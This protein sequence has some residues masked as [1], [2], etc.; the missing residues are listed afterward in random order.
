MTPTTPPLYPL[1]FIP[2]YQQKIWGG[3]EICKYKSLPISLREIGETWEISAMEDAESI[4]ATGALAGQ[5]LSEVIQMYGAELLGPAIYAQYGT[6]F[7][8]LVKL[9]DAQHH[10]SVQVHPSDEQAVRL[11]EEHGKSEAWYLLQCTPEASIYAGWKREL[12]REELHQLAQSEE[13]MKAMNHFTPTPGD[14]FYLPAGTIHA[15]G[16]GC[17]LLEVQQPSDLTY[18][19]FDYNRVDSEGNKR[20]LHLKEAESVLTYHQSKDLQIL[21]PKES[22]TPRTTLL[23]TPHF[24]IDK[25]WLGG[26][27][28]VELISRE[29]F[30]I[31]FVEEGEALLEYPHGSD[32]LKRGDFLLL[33]ASIPAYHLSLLSPAT[34][35]LEIYL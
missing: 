7:P 9:I 32:L 10:L 34:T 13:I 19:I 14:L 3:S 24:N 22:H 25:Y 4:V 31:L 12:Q 6:T 29:T 20:P 5:K 16:A 27:E 8:L 21:Y 30:S 23:Q 17:L 1:R 33:P 26:E 2:C 11:G 35:L 18:R 15:I 28:K